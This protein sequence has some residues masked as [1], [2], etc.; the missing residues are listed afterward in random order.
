M[1]LEFNKPPVSDGGI[2][3]MFWQ[4]DE[5]AIKE[6]ERKYG[7]YLYAIAYNIL[8]D[9][10]DTEECLDDAY[11]NAW[12]AIPPAKPLC[13]QSFLA[14]IVRRVAINCYKSKNRQK[15]IP[16]AMTQSLDELDG[17]IGEQYSADE[18]ELSMLISEFVRALP[19]RRLYI[20]MSR[21]YLSRTIDE[22]ASLLG[23][24]RSTVNKEIA[25]IKRDLREKLEKEGI[26]P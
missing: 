16:S 14:A 18:K 26:K 12:N 20:F 24:S 22:I 15:R 19:E 4:R 6:A 1:K 17:M 8:G 2:I 23:V 7:K 9:H 25:I 21:Y 13:L 10:G 11:V 3:D 5:R